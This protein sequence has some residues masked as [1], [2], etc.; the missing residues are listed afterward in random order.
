MTLN[1]QLLKALL[2]AA[3]LLLLL[4][5]ARAIEITGASLPGDTTLKI[6][7]G[8]VG[9]NISVRGT[10]EQVDTTYPWIVYVQGTDCYGNQIY[11]AVDHGTVTVRGEITLGQ[12]QT[13]AATTA[14]FGGTWFVPND[15]TL[16]NIVGGY[17]MFVRF[18]NLPAVTPAT[19]F[20]YPSTLAELTQSMGLM[21]RNSGLLKI[22][23]IPNLAVETP[24]VTYPAAGYTY[25]GGDIIEFV[26][27][28]F[29]KA[30]K[31]EGDRESRPL[32]ATRESVDEITDRY[33]AD[34]RLT[35][36]P[37]FEDTNNDDFL[38]S[39]LLFS[40]DQPIIVDGVTIARKVQVTGTPPA[41]P[42]YGIGDYNLD[43]APPLIVPT[44]RV[45]TPQ[46]DDG[47]LDL[48]ET[49]AVTTEA[50]IPSN[51][52]GDYFVALKVSM[53][54]PDNDARPGNNTFVSNSA[55]KL[56]IADSATPTTEPAS[57][58]STETG[59]FVA[60]GN[61][62]SDNSSVS[63]DG[64][65]VV[66]SSRASN[67]LVPPQ[68]AGGSSVPAGYA[69]SNQQIFMKFPE[70]GEMRLASRNSG[71]LQANADCGNP[72]I[73]ADGRFI[74]YNS[75]ASNLASKPISGRSA[76][77]VYN[78]Q[79][80]T[81]T[82]VSVRANGDMANG[83]SFRPRL[84]QTGRFVVFESV[85]TNL[86]DTRT[87]TTISGQQIY[88]HDRDTDQD[89][90]FDEAGAID[91]Y[92]VSINGSNVAANGNCLRAVVNL[93]DSVEQIAKNG[94]MYVAYTSF[95]PNLPSGTGQGRS[96]VY[97][98]TVAD[99]G[100]GVRA[101]PSSVVLVSQNEMG[102]PPAAFGVDPVNAPIT[103]L[104]DEPA[105]NGDGSQ[106]AYMSPATNLIRNENDPLIFNYTP[107]YPN[108]PNDATTPVIPGVVPGGDFNRVP[109]IFLRNFNKPLNFPGNGA[110]VRVSVSQ[111][112]VP[113][114][115]ITFQ[116][117]AFSPESAG[118]P[119]VPWPGQP[120][121]NIPTF[122]PTDGDALTISDGIAPVV[123]TFR[124]VPVG[125]NDVQIGAT[126]QATRSDL[127]RV[128]NTS[129]LLIQAEITNP[130][131]V[132]S[133]TTGLPAPGTGY[134]PSIYLRN[135]VRGSAGNV[136]IVF[137]PAAAATGGR[138]VVD[139][140]AG[141]GSQ[142]EDDARA[143]AATGIAPI[144]G[145]PFGSREPS[146]D[147]TG[148]FVAFR[149]NA[150]NLDVFEEN[151][152]N[153]FPT[154]PAKGELNRPLVFPTSN[155]YLHDRQA[156]A[157]PDNTD[158]LFFDTAIA[159]T[160]VSVN[161]FGYKTLID[162]GQQSGRGADTSASS[163]SPFV[164]ANGRFISFS[165]DSSGEGGLIF[166]QNNL[167]YFDNSQ[168]RDVFLHDRRTV[169]DNPT[170]PITKPDVVITA[171][172][173]GLIVTP[174]TDV[175]IN[176]TA[177]PAYGKAITSA[178]L[179]INGVNQ[180]VLT[181]TPFSWTYRVQTA[182]TF[183]ANVIATDSSGVTGNAIIQ[184]NSVEPVVPSNPPANTPQKFVIDYFRKIFLRDPTYAEY[185]LYLGMLNSGASQSEVVIAMMNS[186]E[187][188]TAPNILY[189]YYLRMG[190]SP[191][192]LTQVRA[193]LDT[194]TTGTSN[195]VLLPA[196]MS[197]GLTIL[198]GLPPSP[199]G[200]NVGQA[201][202]AQALI[203]SIPYTWS[204]SLVRNLSDTNFRAWMLRSFNQPYLPQNPTNSYASIGNE[205]VILSNIA[206]YPSPTNSPSERFGY[207]YAFMS[208]FYAVV[209]N[210]SVSD[211]SLRTTLSNFNPTVKGIAANYLLS[212]S[213]TWATNTPQLS[214]NLVQ[215]L[216]P[217]YITNTGTN[218]IQVGFPVTNQVGGQNMSTNT[219]FSAS[220]LP[221]GL[222]INATNGLISGTPTSA[223][224][225]TN[226]MSKLY[227][228]TLVASNSPSLLGTNSFV[229]RVR[230]PAPIITSATNVTGTNGTNF[231]YQIVATNF[232][233]SYA[234]SGTLPTNVLFDS[235]N[236]RLVGVLSNALG[237]YNLVMSAI[238]DGGTN[239]NSLRITVVAPSVGPRPMAVWLNSYGVTNHSAQSLSTSAD[240]YDV[241]TKYAF[242]LDPSRPD[243]P[244][245]TITF[246]AQH[247]H[248]LWL[249]RTDNTVTY[250]VNAADE[251]VGPWQAV[252]PSSISGASEWNGVTGP[253]DPPSGY[254]WRRVTL[255]RS[256]LGN[257]KFFQINASISPAAVIS[258]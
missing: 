39:R 195:T 4:P 33:V 232:P 17:R 97:R 15:G 58:V 118:N 215:T 38:L 110:V 162:G 112:R 80:L 52:A 138:M 240:F 235:F 29:N 113:T 12:N 53:S 64:S 120:A 93:E 51:Y 254:E 115:T 28:W 9:Y 250:V 14:N 214:T 205:A 81:T 243:I 143:F 121:G 177:T 161:K 83:D 169:G 180:A 139:G 142:A 8:S 70:T 257:R 111:Q 47:Y 190:L 176:A 49:V 27:T 116:S 91:T 164:S 88:L 114:G 37:V 135:L 191:S 20:R 95:A 178:V 249:R 75:R 61:A 18:Y 127:A 57:V 182:G 202:V 255:P 72:S 59:A 24:A 151:D 172:V 10:T 196:A 89:G 84:S 130:P 189:G 163:S 7:D 145:V 13:L 200:A 188:N 1:R 173:N 128:I 244:R 30:D 218:T 119:P 109:D 144:Q 209:P 40:A 221:P 165:S 2:V 252:N 103:A 185:T 42:A 78:A 74:A 48:G 129:T 94:G 234:I 152:D 167:T 133:A 98:V 242:G 79:S 213:N 140:M 101:V 123:F 67:L 184:I 54:D 43:P 148:R 154:S 204:N 175:V 63:E 251:I 86:D 134:V 104:A 206:T 258:P 194:M 36:N 168:V 222:S 108:N 203:E 231:F 131:N 227:P 197:S 166:G 170:P 253:S 228:V 150:T 125:P 137:T 76:I 220:G 207:S 247:F 179:Q 77:F 187:F 100:G 198:T 107:T 65:I 11:I 46:P 225:G 233:R 96:L 186:T 223:A 90:V 212:A 159:T 6:L 201:K 126:V 248:I 21:N 99:D 147:R 181:S 210:S 156:D 149:S 237:T 5:C 230:P 34:L 219:R 239:T 245:W 92:L 66:F 22:N 122:Q 25:R 216:L 105:I 45:Y 226:G 124:A 41:P 68:Q 19:G 211:L 132:V 50:M 31:A 73:S 69:T 102:Q 35:T 3:M 60:G 155:I 192:S 87:S 136:P 71:L 224:V 236:G 146:L 217:P 229:Y 193:F 241:N 158:P 246:D 171:P 32:K 23:V 117:T 16:H 106:V 82:V 199:Y 160:R 157:Q 85:A 238:N 141:G 183:I 26:S 208:A 62:A 256:G 174:G 55:N 44:T 56:Y 153:V